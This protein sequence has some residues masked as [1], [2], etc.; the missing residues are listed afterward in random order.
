MVKIRFFTLLRLYLGIRETDIDIG[1][2]AKLK[3]VLDKCE[4]VIG[5]TFMHK[6]LDSGSLMSSSIVLVN[7][8]N[9]HHLQ[10]LDTIIKD[11]DEISLFPPGGGG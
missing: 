7:G 4:H 11:G 6:L 5:R 9:V 2:N 10:G 1:H 3:D 8:K